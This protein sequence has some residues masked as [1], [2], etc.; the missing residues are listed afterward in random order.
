MGRD[1]DNYLIMKSKTMDLEALLEE[2]LGD[3][4]NR[5]DEAEDYLMIY[6]DDIVDDYEFSFLD[7]NHFKEVCGRKYFVRD[8]Y[9]VF[10]AQTRKC[11]LEASFGGFIKEC[12]EGLDLCR[13]YTR[14]VEDGSE[15]NR[16]DFIKGDYKSYYY[17]D[18]PDYFYKEEGGIGKFILEDCGIRLITEPLEQAS[19]FGV[20]GTDTGRVSVEYKSSENL[21]YVLEPKDPTDM[22]QEPIHIGQCPLCNGDVYSENDPSND[23]T[24]SRRCCKCTWNDNQFMTWEEMNSY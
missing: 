22:F 8:G 3:I 21:G 10:Y 18:L 5:N 1:V 6:G 7:K 9:L 14:C 4:L 11:D 19:V 12:R 2:Y 17:G 13:M 16:S 20:V 24:M 23:Y 15:L